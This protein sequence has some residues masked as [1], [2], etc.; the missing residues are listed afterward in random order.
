MSKELETSPRLFIKEIRVSRRSSGL[1]LRLDLKDG[2][3]VIRGENSSGRTT[4]LKLLEFGLGAKIPSIPQFFIPE[5]EECD[6][7]VL[8]VELNG[9]SYTISRKIHRGLGEV[10]VYQGEIDDPLHQQETTLLAGEEF[11]TFLLNRLGIPRVSFV[12]SYDRERAITFYD[13]YDALYLDQTGGFSEIHARIRGETKRINIF[14][15]LTKTSVPELYELEVDYESLILE[16]D[17]I[18]HEADVISRFLGSLEIPSAIELSSRVQELQRQQTDIQSQRDRIRQQMRARTGHANPLREEVLAL[19]AQIAGKGRDFVH[20]RQTLQSYAELENQLREDL[21]RAKRVRTSAL[22]LSSFDF[23]R[24]PRCLQE[25]TLEM[26]RHELHEG[27]SL[28]GRPLVRRSDDTTGVEAYERQIL[29]QLDEL[30]D[31]REQYNNSITQTNADLSVLQEELT[32]KQ[33][34]LDATLEQYLSPLVQEIEALAYQLANVG[35]EINRLHALERW[36]GKLDQMQA[37]LQIVR[38]KM[39]GLQRRR[40]ELQ[41]QEKIL[42]GSLQKFQD[43]YGRFVTDTYPDFVTVTLDRGD[44]LPRINNR[45][46]R[47]KSATQKNL[48][49]LGYY[50]ALLRYSLEI[51]SY[52]P[53]FLVVD[54]LRQD[55]LSPE[56]YE[57]VLRKFKDLEQIYHTGFQAFVV[58]RESLE[59]LRDDEVVQLVDGRRLLLLPA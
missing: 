10:T 49:I 48:A 42:Q 50:Y 41:E 5:I 18:K 45:D 12:D 36:L 2:L 4:L 52:I 46:Y 14:K 28:C 30:T 8:Q 20:A 19:E 22:Q 59:F 16:S 27:C 47:A 24:C 15:L 58:I 21:D 56:L 43:F 25:I 33:Q 54:T 23:E 13:L 11:S 55:D 40:E 37:A 39:E 32:A 44:F 7:V 34:S 17:K 6:Q 29:A 31:L 35:E 1:A 3:N 38:E 51:S 26:K 57:K 9:V 53:R